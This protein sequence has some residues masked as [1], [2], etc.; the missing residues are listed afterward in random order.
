MKGHNFLFLLWRQGLK[1]YIA[2]EEF[3][4]W[5]INIPYDVDRSQPWEQVLKSDQKSCAR[6]GMLKVRRG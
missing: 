2:F 3:T 4:W 1:M 5:S 6:Q